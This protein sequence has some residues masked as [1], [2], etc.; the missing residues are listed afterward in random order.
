MV[1]LYHNG[2]TWTS[3]GLLVVLLFSAVRICLGKY[4][5]EFK[6]KAPQGQEQPPIE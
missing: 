1:F 2:F 4:I 3:L 6:R 5:I